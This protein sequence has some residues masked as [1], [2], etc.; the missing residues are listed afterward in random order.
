MKRDG[1]GLHTEMSPFRDDTFYVPEPL[2]L[3]AALISDAAKELHLDNNE[4]ERRLALR[5]DCYPVDTE[6]AGREYLRAQFQAHCVIPDFLKSNVRVILKDI[7]IPREANQKR[8]TETVKDY[9]LKPRNYLYGGFTNAVSELASICELQM[10]LCDP[11]EYEGWR[12]RKEMLEAVTIGVDFQTHDYRQ[13]RE[14]LKECKEMMG[15]IR[16]NT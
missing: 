13:I 5:G 16:E 14:G 4:A 12:V 1:P 3:V 2:K 9:V 11:D 15:K 7:P 8:F 10:E 6:S